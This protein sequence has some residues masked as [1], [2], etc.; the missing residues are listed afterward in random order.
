MDTLAR[1]RLRWE[2]IVDELKTLGP[3]RSGSICPM[4]VHS[5]DKHGAPKSHG[6]YL[7]HT[8]KHRGK[9]VTRRLRDAKQ[10][11]TCRR[12]IAN[13]RRFEQLTAQLRRLGRQLAQWEDT[14]PMDQKKT[15]RR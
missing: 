13:F 9:T 5:T 3:M 14:E 11:E 6:P 15:S 1:L 2:K 8:Y 4:T 7:I 10:I 12:Q